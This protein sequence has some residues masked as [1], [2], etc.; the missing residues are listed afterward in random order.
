MLLFFQPDGVNKIKLFDQTE[1]TTKGISKSK[2]PAKTQC[3]LN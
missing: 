1:F 3:E 2:F